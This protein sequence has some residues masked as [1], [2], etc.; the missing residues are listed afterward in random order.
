MDI[1]KQLRDFLVQNQQLMRQKER[2]GDIQ[3][4]DVLKPSYSEIRLVEQLIGNFAG[5]PDKYVDSL[6]ENAKFLPYIPNNFVEQ[7]SQNDFYD[8]LTYLLSKYQYAHKGMSIIAEAI[9][10][11][12]NFTIPILENISIFRRQLLDDYFDKK[13]V[14]TL[15]LQRDNMD[16]KFSLLEIINEF[17]AILPNIYSD[18]DDDLKSVGN[19]IFAMEKC[20]TNILTI[21]TDVMK[22]FFEEKENTDNSR[23]EIIDALVR[24]VH[25]DIH[26]PP[27]FHHGIKTLIDIVENPF[28]KPSVSALSFAQRLVLKD[29]TITEETENYISDSL[30]LLSK[31]CSKFNAQL[32]NKRMVDKIIEYLQ[33][34]NLTIKIN[35]INLVIQI[36]SG[37][38]PTPI[39]MLY[40]QN[41]LDYLLKF[42]H[43]YPKK[44]DQPL[45]AASSICIHGPSYVQFI[46]ESEFI[47]L[48]QFSVENGGYDV[49]FAAICLVSDIIRYGA[50]EHIRLINHP[51]II[52]TM[53]ELIKEECVH[54][55]C[56]L[57][58]LNKA[59]D[60]ST[61]SFDTDFKNS[62]STPEF[63]TVLQSLSDSEEK[64]VPEFSS[65]LYQLLT[66]EQS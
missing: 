32:A 1:H 37:K 23:W 8:Q 59:M 44:A 29:L 20:I 7:L 53:M 31:V 18:S 2:F 43:D 48:I 17:L 24:R 47:D 39:D 62:L 11:I 4:N 13:L 27:L 5:D 26:K 42:A 63:L 57:Y 58:S 25:M 56:I 15:P 45:I 40:S 30:V 54:V 22:G 6:F 51:K 66:A 35:T 41:L 14:N 55:D 28:I 9:S 10:P 46:C 34:D 49:Q 33:I 38:C 36:C 65:A 16:R 12:S 61:E 50:I 19:I 60:P 64:N 21:R 3:S 52:E